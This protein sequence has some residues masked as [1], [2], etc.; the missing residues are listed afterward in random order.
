MLQTHLSFQRV[1][2]ANTCHLSYRFRRRNC[3]VHIVLRTGIQG[4]NIV[5]NYH[6]FRP[7]FLTARR[8]YIMRRNDEQAKK[9][10]TGILNSF[11][12][13]TVDMTETFKGRVC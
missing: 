1:Y 9:T 11:G 13:E 8:L 7:A 12:W 5:G 2:A 10:V 6:M 3:V 4:F